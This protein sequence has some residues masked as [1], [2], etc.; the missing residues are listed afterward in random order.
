M[1][2]YVCC[3][4]KS[5]FWQ[6]S[7]GSL[8]AADRTENM[9]TYE[10]YSA[11]SCTIAEAA[12]AIWKDRAVAFFIRF[13]TSLNTFNQ[14]NKYYSVLIFMFEYREKNFSPL[15]RFGHHRLHQYMK[16]FTD[17]IYMQFTT[18]SKH[19]PVDEFKFYFKVDSVVYLFPEKPIFSSIS[20]IRVYIYRHSF[21]A[22]KHPCVIV[23]S[24]CYAVYCRLR[25][26]DNYTLL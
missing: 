4:L 7:A 15:M 8:F 12:K 26:A 17:S 25:S 3:S 6:Y 5:L 18:N 23:L 10:I 1:F 19:L 22:K 21:F 24:N 2:Y 14:T 16:H 11:L 9:Q 13:E 20:I